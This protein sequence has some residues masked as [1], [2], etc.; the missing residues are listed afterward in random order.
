MT[1]PV[2]GKEEPPTPSNHDAGD[3][4]RPL[5]LQ[6]R[7]WMLVLAVVAGVL[8]LDGSLDRGAQAGTDRV[9]RQA[10]LTYAAARSLDAA[11]SLAE[12]TELAL[13][14]GGVGVTISAGEI[15]EPLDDLV[16][17][18]SSLMLVSA[19]S[20]GLQSLL[21]R[22]SAWGV[23]TALL[24]LFLLARVGMAF[25]PHRV[26]P[27]V[28]RLIST[29]TT[30]LLVARFAVPL[31]GVATTALFE[32]YLQ[33]GQ[34]E[35]VQALEETSTDVRELEQLDEP[36]VDPGVVGRVSRWF[37]GA[38]DRLDVSERVE[39]LRDRVGEVVDQ[40]VHLLVVFVLQ[41]L[42][43]PLV[44]LWAVGRVLAAVTTRR[45]RA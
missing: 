28:G 31:Y 30:L 42:V 13:E 35:A 19:T 37:S 29:G 4:S 8:S 11:V 40:L 7:P 15:L 17:Q 32:R 45:A 34:E 20:L 39:A 38:M 21:L 12:G 3:A 24:L 44:F 6:A 18:F 41:T 14:P 1:P 36:E 26:S 43:L 33:P 10:L 23:L 25:L 2:P 22:A 27:G 9:F 5:W 16:E